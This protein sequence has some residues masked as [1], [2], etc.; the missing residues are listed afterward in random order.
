MFADP[1]DNSTTDESGSS[2]LKVT[3]QT[4]DILPPT[5]LIGVDVRDISKKIGGKRGR[6]KPNKIVKPVKSRTI[7]VERRTRCDN[8]NMFVPTSKSKAKKLCCCFCLK[9]YRKL[10]RHLENVHKNEAEVKKMKNLPIG[11]HTVL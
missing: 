7:N 8:V 5:P 6:T 1:F 10:A 11:K 9:R 4:I 3:Q 2:N